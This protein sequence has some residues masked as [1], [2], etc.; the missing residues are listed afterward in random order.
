MADPEEIA[1]S[2]SR[3]YGEGIERILTI[4]HDALEPADSQRVFTLL[5]K[6]EFVEQLLCLHGLHP[7]ALEERVDAALRSVLPYVSSHKGNIRVAR[8]EGDVVYVVLE[9]TCDGCAASSATLKLLVERAILE[10]APE[11]REVRAEEPL[12]LRVLEKVS[13]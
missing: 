6:D 9:G 13:V 5:C 4:V 12:T 11:I 10:R 3:M 1:R 8:I 7:V 2:V